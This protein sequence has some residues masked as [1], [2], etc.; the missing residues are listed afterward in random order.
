MRRLI[1]TTASV[2]ALGIGGVGFAHAQG[3]SNQTGAAAK[4]P[5]A[6]TRQMHKMSSRSTRTSATRVSKSEVK[7]AQQA[8]REQGLYRGRIDGVLG[9]KTKTALRNFQ[10]K[11]GLPA[12]ASLDRRTMA[13]LSG[14]GTQ[15]QGSS[16]P[17][18]SGKTSA[19]PMTPQN[20]QM[21]QTGNAGAGAGNGAATGG[22]AT[23]G[24]GPSTG[25]QPS[26]QK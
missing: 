23:A 17:S 26:P 22:G 7:Q 6:P 3:Y 21:G 8:L 14:G 20:G 19:A 18:S 12:T 4:M 13:S 24:E 1:L 11:N 10:R 9:P 2:L 25:A 15:G 5:S 16:M